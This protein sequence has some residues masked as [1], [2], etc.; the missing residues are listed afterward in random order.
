MHT[1][2]LTCAWTCILC[3]LSECRFT[4]RLGCRCESRPWCAGAGMVQS[5]KIK[6]TPAPLLSQLESLPSEDWILRS[7]RPRAEV[8][9][10]VRSNYL[11]IWVMWYVKMKCI[12]GLGFSQV[13]YL[14]RG[15]WF[16]QRFSHCPGDAFR[17]LSVHENQFRQ[18]QDRPAVD[19]K[20]QRLTSVRW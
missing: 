20:I 13:R 18:G 12:V 11:D 16:S 6:D 7:V 8:S 10:S 17:Y 4:H 1:H 3:Q 15:S 14:Q 19:S 5:C 9:L 2:I